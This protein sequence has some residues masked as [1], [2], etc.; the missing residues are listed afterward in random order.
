MIQPNPYK[1][2]CPKCDYSKIVTPKSD[3]LISAIDLS[4]CP[5]CNIRLEKKTITTK[6]NKSWF[7]MNFGK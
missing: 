1:L 5:K 4:I 2:V 3:V 6:E 7:K